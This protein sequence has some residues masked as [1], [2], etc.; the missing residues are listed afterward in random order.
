M[1]THLAIR[2]LAGKSPGDLATFGVTAL[3]PGGDFGDEQRALGQASVKALAIKDAD[4][5]FRHIQP[6]G[7]L[8]GV[9]E[10]DPAQELLSRPDTEHC[11]KADWKVRTEIVEH[12]VNAPGFR[13]D[14]FEQMFDEGNE[15]DF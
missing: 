13:V 10:D 9:V 1:A 11:F 7:V 5:D 8:W 12:E 14:V 2:V 6:A 4:L 3:L 15:V